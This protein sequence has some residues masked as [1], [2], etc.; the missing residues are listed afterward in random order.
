VDFFTPADVEREEFYLMV[1]ALAAYKRVEMAMEAFS[2]LGRRLRVV[3]TGPGLRRLR[4]RAPSNVELLGWQDAE[5]LREHYRRCRGVI[6]PQ[7]EEF[8][9]VA[10]EAMACGAPVIAYGAGGALET[11]LDAA[12]ERVEAPTGLLFRPQT[13]GALGAAVMEFEDRAARFDPAALRRHAEQFSPRRFAEGLKRLVGGLLHRRGWAAP[14]ERPITSPG[15][16]RPG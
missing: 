12:D 9:I 4:R 13:P 10:V 6:F 2:S 8:G 5:A 3:G 1:S 15:R 16:S 11:V 14:W 7:L